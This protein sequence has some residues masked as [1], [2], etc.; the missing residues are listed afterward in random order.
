MTN[1][2]MIYLFVTQWQMK[3]LND[4]AK[5]FL[6][7]TLYSWSLDSLVSCVG[8]QFPMTNVSMIYLCVTQWQMQELNDKANVFLTLTLY[9]IHW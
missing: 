6:T 7:L 1:V 3:E 4:K 5:V 2:S 9:N 8:W